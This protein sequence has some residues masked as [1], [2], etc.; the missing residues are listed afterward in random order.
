MVYDEYEIP[1]QL[2]YSVLEALIEHSFSHFGRATIIITCRLQNQGAQ[3]FQQAPAFQVRGLYQPGTSPGSRTQ[4]AAISRAM[5]V[6]HAYWWIHSSTDGDG[7]GLGC[8]VSHDSRC[9]RV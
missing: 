2:Q 1:V 9:Y 8:K 7:I 3:L 4:G 5:N 6:R